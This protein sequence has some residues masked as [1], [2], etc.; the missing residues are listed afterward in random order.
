LKAIQLLLALLCLPLPA[1]SET[2]NV[3]ITPM[4]SAASLAG[5]W[6]PLLAEVGRRAGVKLAFRTARTFLHSARAW[7]AAITTWP[8]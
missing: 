7:P 3:G 5:D 4:K 1:H 6:S 8:T 2:L